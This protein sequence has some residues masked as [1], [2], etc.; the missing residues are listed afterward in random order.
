[1]LV[2]E[3][4]SLKD[5]LIGSAFIWQEKSSLRAWVRTNYA[6]LMKSS[7][8]TVL[9][10]YASEFP[11]FT[12]FW[13]CWWLMSMQEHS[14]LSCLWQFI[15][16]EI[17]L[18]LSF[19]QDAKTLSVA[20]TRAKHA[21]IVVVDANVWKEIWNY[22][23]AHYKEKWYLIREEDSVLPLARDNKTWVRIVVLHLLLI[24]GIC[25]CFWLLKFKVR[26]LTQLSVVAGIGRTKPTLDCLGKLV[27][28]IVNS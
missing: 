9:T 3:L 12:T 22:L 17:R 2:M 14:A 26:G 4:W 27:F 1:M 6:P 15:E 8:C 19:V 10:N 23:M 24:G 13:G 25:F 5:L 16:L 21:L 20:I 28:F 11:S 18:L 7:I